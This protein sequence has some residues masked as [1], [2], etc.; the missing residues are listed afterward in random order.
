MLSDIRDVNLWA[1]RD[2]ITTMI[3]SIPRT[4][5]CRGCFCFI[6]LKSNY[7]RPMPWTLRLWVVEVVRLWAYELL[8]LWVHELLSLWVRYSLILYPQHVKLC[9]HTHMPVRC[10]PLKEA[11]AKGVLASRRRQQKQFVTS[12]FCETACFLVILRIIWVYKTTLY[13]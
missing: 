13:K 7:K 11:Q 3:S 9:G 10:T 6:K 2:G 4:S 5:L 12:I 8:S 1:C